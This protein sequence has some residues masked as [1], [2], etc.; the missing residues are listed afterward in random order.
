MSLGN[1][2]NKEEHDQTIIDCFLQMWRYSADLMFIMAVEDGDEFSLYDNNPA[3]KA[4]MGLEKGAEIH[5]LNLRVQFGDEMAEQVYSTYRQVLQGGK[6]V[7]IEQAGMRGDGSQIYFDTLFVP[8]FDALGKPIFVCGVS[9]DIT[10]IKEAEIVALKA[11][12]KLFEYSTALETINQDLDHKVQE[13]TKE[14]ESAKRTVEDALEAKSSFVARMSHEIRTP[15]NAVIGLSH[16]SLKTSL[17]NEQKD[18]INT[19]LSSG[20]TLLS[21]VNDVLDFSK[22]EAGK[23][24]IE[25][26]P[27]SPKSIVQHAVNMNS[28]KAEEKKLAVT[29]DISPSLPPTL[30]GDPLR[31]QQVLINLVTNAVKFTER[32]GICVRMYTDESNDKGVLLR[33]DVIDTG[34]GI[35]KAHAEQL[36]QSFQQA[37]DSITRQFGGTGLGLTISRQLCELMG[38]DIWVHSELGQGSTFSF[39]LPLNIAS[40]IS[41]QEEGMA[42]NEIVKVFINEEIEGVGD[43]K[44]FYGNGKIPDLSQYYVLLA[45]DN[46]IN[47]KVVLGYL[48]DTAINVDVVENGKEAIYKLNNKKYDLVLMDIQ[49]PVMDG[50]AA[51]RSIRQSSVY[52][53][54]PIIAMTAHVSDEARKQSAQAGMNAHLDKPIQKSE[55]Y[56]TLQ[57]HLDGKNTHNSL[58]T[59]DFFVSGHYSSYDAVLSK[60]SSIDTLSIK[61]AIQSLNGKTSLYL[62]IATAFYTKYKV[63][64]LRDFVGSDLS[65]VLHSL[66]SNSAYIGAFELSSYCTELEDAIKHKAP[67]LHFINRLE[68]MVNDLVD[69]LQNILMPYSSLVEYSEDANGFSKKDL[70]IKLKTIVP[71]LKK[72]DFF[73]EN[74][75]SL[76]RKTV[77]GTKYTLDIENLIFDIKN[78][79][80]EIAAV[81]ASQLILELQGD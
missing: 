39:T 5:R 4:V 61:E 79:E 44:L 33:C 25:A 9:R 59:H 14:L 70:V 13:R 60:L 81:K 71:L 80:F 36:F 67:D 7:S 57:K 12:E 8:I 69:S 26:V 17:S 72:S 77:R 3:S 47:Q 48:G 68:S 16:L 64:S 54:I 35:S 10:K 52:G 32:G 56:K 41:I 27:F 46:L 19:I 30:L 34:I 42:S 55:L 40:N 53:N 23:M 49:M 66:K 15:I 38:G 31:I 37:D 11:N 58:Q 28:I 2:F 63:F 43:E 20:E 45:E 50:L 1:A 21:L 76:L 22:I 24:S 62:E 78:I 65:N 75:F 6:P 51:A 74:H 73:V 18:Y 29:V